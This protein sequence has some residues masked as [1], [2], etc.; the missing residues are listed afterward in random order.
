MVLRMPTEELPKFDLDVERTCLGSCLVYPELLRTA[1]AS[2]S[3][4]YGESH[5]VIWRELQY[6]VAEN[7]VADQIHLRTRL[8][9]IGKLAFVGGDD[10]LLDL[11]EG[12]IVVPNPPFDLL[13]RYAKRRVLH[14]LGL[15]LAAAGS[16]DDDEAAERAL[17][18]AQEELAAAA[19]RQPSA[20]DQLWRPIGTWITEQPSPRRWLLTRPDDETNGATSKG[21]LPVGKAGMLFAEGGT[22]KTFALIQLAVSIV[23]GRRWLDYFDVPHTGP[24]LLALGEEDREEIHRRLF[25]VARAMRLTEQQER[26]AGEQI[27][28]LPLAGKLVSLMGGDGATDSEFQRWLRGRLNGQDFRLVV[29]DPLSR[30]AGGDTEKDNASATRFVQQVESLVTPDC[31]VLV[32]HHSR[33]P[34][35]GEA[36]TASAHNARGV[37]ALGAGFRWTA[38]LQQLGTGARF[39]VTKSNYAPRGRPLDLQ[40][41]DDTGYLTYTTA[42]IVPSR[43]EESADRYQRSLTALVDLVRR[44]PGKSRT[45]LI[46]MAGIA[47]ERGVAMFDELEAGGLL[48]HSIGDRGA[49]VMHVAGSQN[50]PSG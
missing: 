27:I 16:V 34:S 5:K 49:K 43:M 38:E 42:P 48:A 47:K 31:T 36:A 4:F 33:K 30:F 32:S 19:P 13:R 14:E 46:A 11:T 21:V 7:G 44:H 8:V 20:L 9:E 25:A 22:G 37:T 35:T 23:T 45:Q 28:A 6:L 26:L 40:R 1:E 50:G 18:D 17:R 24:V 15:R 3:D 10:Y 2:T 39:A 41:D 12:R 29:I